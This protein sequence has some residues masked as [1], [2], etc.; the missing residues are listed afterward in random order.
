MKSVTRRLLRGVINSSKTIAVVLSPNKAI[1][2]I[3]GDGGFY[4]RL[5][6]L[7]HCPELS[8]IQEIFQALKYVN[9]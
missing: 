9:I 7:L 5:N 4:K 1:S 2:T 8:L 6:F 3:N